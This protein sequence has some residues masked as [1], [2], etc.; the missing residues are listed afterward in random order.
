MSEI[1]PFHMT[2][3]F[4]GGTSSLV[5]HCGNSGNFSGNSHQ[6]GYKNIKWDK[7]SRQYFGLSPLHSN[8]HHL[9]FY[10]LDSRISN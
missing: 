10:I 3:R 4:F 5:L 2:L 6:V 9:D 7:G 8:S 1:H